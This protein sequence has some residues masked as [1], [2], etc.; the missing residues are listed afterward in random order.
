MPINNFSQNNVTTDDLKI[1]MGEWTG[2]LTYTDYG[3]NKPFTMP[4]KL[5]VSQGKNDYQLILNINYP[6]EPNANSKD[7]IKISKNGTLLNKHEVKSKVVLP[8]GQIQITTQYLGKDNGKQA[9]IK[10]IYTIGTSEFII[11][12]E[13]KFKNSDNWLMRNEYKYIR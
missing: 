10:N 7:K 5:I 2:T 6:K 3:T 12:K 4:A 9:F 1:I 13:V 8:N 11:R